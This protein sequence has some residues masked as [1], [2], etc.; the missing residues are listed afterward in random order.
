MVDTYVGN[1]DA[2]RANARASLES[3]DRV[4][5]PRFLIRDLKTYAANRQRFLTE[6]GYGYEILYDTDVLKKPS[7]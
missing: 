7:E 3:S 2:A 1:V 4:D 5:D 6:Q